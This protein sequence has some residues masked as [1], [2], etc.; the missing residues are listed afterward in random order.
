MTSSA[1]DIAILGAGPVGRVLALMLARVAP[2]PARIALL[3]GSPPAP[4]APS[5]AAPATDPRV[6]AM[7]H[8]SRVLLEAL[9]AWPDR[10]A[11]IRNI[12]VSQ[13]GRLGRTLI[14]NTDF[15]VPQLGSVVAYS[16]LHAKL[17]ECV[18]ACGVTVLPG[19]PARIGLQDADGV[20]VHQGDTTLLCRVAV[21]SDGAGANDVR[22]DYDQHAVLTTA[23]ATLPRR[24][25]AWERFTAEGPLALLPHP[26]TPDA[27]SVVWC[28]TPERAAEVAALDNA[29]FSRALSQ[30]FGDR[31]GRLSSQAP[32][33]VFPLAL[34]ARRA[35][36]HGRVAAI[37]N[38][39]QTLHPVAGQGLNLG[40]RDAARL[41][42]TLGGWL[43]HPEV[44]PASALAEFAGARHVDRLIT[45]GLT[46]LMPRI[47]STGL[48]PVEHACG[49]ALLGMDLAS[50]LRAPLAQHLLQ[51]F[52]A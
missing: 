6:L 29:A 43:P 44:N 37:G 19:P 33:H 41:A 18:A 4:V 51:G 2:D 36:V 1:F 48:A 15:G 49:L 9:H 31:L 5:A 47:F 28:C 21:Q 13:R 32:R 34:S 30:A 39:A 17:D 42:Q 3:A 12:H 35:Q 14:Q 24:G 23:H 25:W 20:R 11:D 38:A 16:G 40:L 26:Q 10:S 22:R 27:Y 50:P 45:A 52:R 7:N 8:G 46:D